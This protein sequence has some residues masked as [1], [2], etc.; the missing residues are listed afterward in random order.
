MFGA[1]PKIVALIVVRTTEPRCRLKRTKA[2]HGIIPLLNPPMILF[3]EI[4]EIPVRP[5]FY[6][7]TQYSA[8][9]TRIRVVAVGRHSDRFVADYF[10][11]PL[12]ETLGRIHVS[13]LQEHGIYQVTTSVNRSVKVAPFAT[14]FDLRFV[15]VPR[16]T[17]FSFTPE[18]QLLGDHRR[19]ARLPVSHCLVGELQSSLQKH[20]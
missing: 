9:C 10:F 12:E 13:L 15:D 2:A 5:V 16:V 6:L 4:I 11:G 18:T 14:D 19:E 8:Y 17:S 7:A 3:Q 20:L 1:I